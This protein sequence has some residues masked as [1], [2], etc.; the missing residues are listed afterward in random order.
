LKCDIC[1]KTPAFGNTISHSK[2]HT[3]RMWEPN[4]HSAIIMLDG[5]KKRLNL[6]TRC[7]RNQHKEAKKPV[8]RPGSAAVS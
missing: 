7:I 6:C 5:K 1:G 2:R 4:V 8:V 3:N